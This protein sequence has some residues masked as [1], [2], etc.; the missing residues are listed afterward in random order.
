MVSVNLRKSLLGLL[1]VFG[2]VG[3]T[4]H[5]GTPEFGSVPYPVAGDQWAFVGGDPAGTWF[6]A[7]T[8]INDGNAAQLG[9]A[10]AYDMGTD[11]GQEATPLVVDGVMYTSGVWGIVYALDAVTGKLLWQFDPGIDPASARNACCDTV[12]RGVAVRDGVVFVAS[13]DGKLHALDARTGAE[14]W[15][16]D[17]IINRNQTYASTGAVVLTGDAVVIGNSGADLG[18][19]S[20]R[21]YISAWDIRTGAFKWRFF[22][23]PPAPGQPFEHPELAMAAKSWGPDHDGRYQNGGTVWDGLS[24]DAQTDQIVFGTANASP[25]VRAK[26]AAERHDDLFNASIIAVNARS[27]RMNWYYQETPGDAWDYDAVQKFIFATLPIGGQTH[28]VVMQ[29]SKNGFYYTLDLKT[30]KLLAADAFTYVNWAS[31]VDLST[32]RPRFT[33]IADYSARPKNVYPSWAGGHTWNPMSFSPATGLVYIPTL[34]VPNVMVNLPANHGALDHLEG[35]FNANGIIPDDTYDLPTLTRLYGPL[36]DKATLQK[37]RGKTNL[38]REVLKA[39]DPVQRKVVWEQVTSQG[40]RGYDGGVLSTA[41][42]IVVQ[43]RGDGT[44]RVYN[45]TTGAQITSIQTGTHIM[46]A[47]MTYRIGGV[48]YIA[49]QAGYGGIGIS[50]PIPP[51]DAAYRNMNTNRILVFKLGGGPVPQPEPR[52]DPFT[53]PAPPAL[54]ASPAVIAHG[55]A[56]FTEYCSRCHVFGPGVTPDLSRLP[57]EVHGMF[58][59][60]V[61]KG[62]LAQLGM[63]PLADVVS[64]DDVE[65]IHAY[66]IDQ[67]RQGYMAQHKTAAK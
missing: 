25:Y 39:W 46:A 11:R 9:F 62:A 56:K 5:A 57:P 67:Q 61:L 41:G 53:Y 34:D 43:G 26:S 10:W 50:Y 1:C 2:V 6:S 27:G 54:Q 30:G 36:P 4:L 3:S 42:N 23:V 44:L 59:D 45:A 17:T 12:N 14:K 18:D 63:A 31:G 37:E 55:E 22:T 13:E 65:A 40:N 33:P 20:T 24:Y 16:A 48:Q 19:G 60:I 52:P 7:L 64:K 49:V 51:G 28:R 47:P 35:F 21:G 29:A 15:S 8:Q 32:G 58:N 38:V 66:L